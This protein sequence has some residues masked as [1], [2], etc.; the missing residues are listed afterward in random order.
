[1][2]YK[3]HN[4]WMTSQSVASFNKLMLNTNLNCYSKKILNKAQI[5]MYQINANANGF[6]NSWQRTIQMGYITHGSLRL[7]CFV[8]MSYRTGPETVWMG[9]ITHQFILFSC[10][11]AMSN[12]TDLLKMWLS[13]LMMFWFTQIV[14]KSICGFLKK[15]Y[16]VCKNRI[17]KKT[18]IYSS[19][20]TT[21]WST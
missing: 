7:C 8:P 20:E 21:R 14:I 11:L 2:N 5:K 6:H 4:F 10:F 3:L 12:G 13:T 19:V 17:L 16:S 9:N 1:M 15:Y 18:W